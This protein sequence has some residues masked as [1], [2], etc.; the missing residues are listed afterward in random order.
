MGNVSS[1]VNKSFYKE[2]IFN[3]KYLS[4]RKTYCNSKCAKS[5]HFKGIS[6]RSSA[7]YIC[8]PITFIDNVYKL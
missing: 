3:R 5:F 8:L 7:E 2:P 4:A 1:I 6:P